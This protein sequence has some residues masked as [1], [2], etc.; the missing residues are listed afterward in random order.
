MDVRKRYERYNKYKKSVKIEEIDSIP[1][2][3]ISFKEA[4]KKVKSSVA[5]ISKKQG[6]ESNDFFKGLLS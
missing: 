5:N 2:P 6:I 1:Y 4:Q 3:A